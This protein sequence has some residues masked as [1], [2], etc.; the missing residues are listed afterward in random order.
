MG[1]KGQGGRGK[2]EEGGWKWV[3]VRGGGSPVGVGRGKEGE[4]KRGG[5]DRGERG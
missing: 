1:R 5:G 3:G 2:E 4:G